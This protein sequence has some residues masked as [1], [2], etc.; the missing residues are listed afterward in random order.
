[1]SDSQPKIIGEAAY[2]LLVRREEVNVSSLLA[3]LARMA[4][5]AKNAQ[6]QQRIASA[7]QWLLTHR[8]PAGSDN[9]AHSALR[10]LSRQEGSVRMPSADADDS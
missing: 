10:G 9:R 8:Q 6:Q 4:E 5:K 7:Q 3:E 2:A 1:M